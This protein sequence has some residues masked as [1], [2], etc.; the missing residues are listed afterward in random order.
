M[1]DTTLHSRCDCWVF[2]LISVFEAKGMFGLVKV[3]VVFSTMVDCSTVN[4][5]FCV[6][7]LLG[8]LT[9]LL[10]VKFLL[11]SPAVGG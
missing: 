11:V 2:V 7:F 3:R 8:K 10:E 5:I 4:N 1:S 6:E 9:L